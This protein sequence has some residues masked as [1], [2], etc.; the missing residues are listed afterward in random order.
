MLTIEFFQHLAPGKPYGDVIVDPIDAPDD[1][2]AQ[3]I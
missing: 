1:W 3:A 2:Y